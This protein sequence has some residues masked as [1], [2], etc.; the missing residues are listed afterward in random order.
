MRASLLPILLLT[1]SF[2]VA[3]AQGEET[4]E[5]TT[6]LPEIVTTGTRSQTD[7]RILPMTVTVIGEEQLTEKQNVNI[8]P[9]LTE[10]VPGLFV[11]Q[12]GVMGYGVSTGGSGG[13]KVRGIGGGSNTDV[14][15]LIDGMPQYAGLY[16]H[17]IADNYQ[18]MLAER[19]EVV[20]GPASLYYGSNALGGVVNIVTHQPKTD[21]VLT[22]LHAQG[23]SYNTFDVGI[24]NQVRK[25]KFS[26]AAGFNYL[27]TDGH[28]DNM[29]FTEYAG[30]LRL[31]YDFTPHW[32]L[33]GFGNGNYFDTHN[34]GTVESPILDSRMKIFRG[35]ATLSLENTHEEGRFPT[36]GAIRAFYN[37]GKHKINDGHAPEAA[38]QS[39]LYLHTDFLA[40]VNIYQSIAFFKGNRTTVGFDFNQFGGHAWNEAIADGST[41]DIID[42]SQHEIAEYVDFRQ[43]LTSW[44]TFDAGIRFNYHD[45]VGWSYI[46]QGGLSFLLPKET[47]IKLL[48]SKGYRNPTLRELYM[49]KPAN[50]ELNPVSLWNYELSYRQHL[51]NRRIC[52]GANLFH[53]RAKDNIETQMVEGKPLNVNTGEIKNTGFEVDFS[54]LITEGLLFSTN[55]SYLHMETPSLG[56]P[57]NKLNVSLNYKHK[58][59]H[60]GSSV[61]YV[62]GLY[63]LV[64]EKTQQE[65]FVLW[66]AHAAYRV[67]K[68]LW[69]NVKGENLLAQEYE[70]N[71]GFPMP[72][73]T[74]FGGIR[75]TF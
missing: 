26:S 24:T 18:T 7:A 28:R 47:E 65:D 29:E 49:Y 13:I 59:L 57:E 17:P 56:S 8:L 42:K 25:G 15:V 61:Q 55:Y 51:L 48:A 69:V 36:S 45:Q 75:W 40:G 23:G 67:W 34:P 19:V 53:L 68:G 60:V 9:T 52:L 30:F 2:S 21:T 70:I 31:G 44:I 12:R 73:T 6:S 10:E 33:V 4:M 66:N 32:K 50:Q 63:T 71:A 64:G 54:Y 62:A 39:Q 22:T 5:Q 58:R 74:L 16:G 20:R 1:T 11:T 43:Q 37:Y 35:M 27:S 46:P 14:L 41:Y 3:N 38:P 72:K